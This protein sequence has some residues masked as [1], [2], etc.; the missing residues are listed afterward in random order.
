MNLAR[1]HDEF[2][3]QTL[4]RYRRSKLAKRMA[5]A[6]SS[7]HTPEPWSCNLGGGSNLTH[8]PEIWAGG[9]CIGMVGDPFVS[10]YSDEDVAN[11]CLIAASPELLEALELITTEIQERTYVDGTMLSAAYQR[12]DV[13]G[14]ATIDKARA[15]IRK[16]KGGA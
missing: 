16:A 5:L 7:K 10:H 15:A 12:G 1:H 11:G 8:S 13:C 9:R 2:S 14:L 4:M 6:M 3:A